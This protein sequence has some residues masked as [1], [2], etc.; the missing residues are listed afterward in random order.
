MHNIQKHIL[1][2]LTHNKTARFAELRPART[3]SNLFSY[4]LKALLKEELVGKIDNGYT[5]TFKGLA[6]VDRVSGVNFEPRLQPKIITM[7]VALNSRGQV[8]TQQRKKQPFINTWTLPSGKLHLKD[9]SILQ[10]AQREM[11]EKT[12]L[13][14]SKLAHVGDFYIKVAYDQEIISSV[15]THVF[16]GNI[17][18]NPILRAELSWQAAKNLDEKLLA[19]AIKEITTSVAD[20][21]GAIFKE[22][23]VDYSG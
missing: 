20:G 8:L 22:I 23:K 7:I 19:P 15:L 6:F 18:G 1:A 9:E 10:A 16:L 14:T 12:G 5:L 17:I 3:D 2:V 11:Q 13:K 21:K 4:H